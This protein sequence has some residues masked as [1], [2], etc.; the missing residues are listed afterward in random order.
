MNSFKWLPILYSNSYCSPSQ[1]SNEYDHFIKTFDQLT[2]H[3]NSL[4]ARLLLITDDFNAKSSSWWSNNVDNIE[5]T[6]FESMA[7]F[8]GLYQIIN[9]PTHFLPSSS[10]CIDLI[11]TNQTRLITDSVVHRSL[12]QNCIHQIIFAKINMIIFYPPCKI[13]N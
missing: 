4:K 11:F 13:Y 10:S 8:Y 12:H 3:I 6:R 9:E 1:S 7:S 2:V 5:G